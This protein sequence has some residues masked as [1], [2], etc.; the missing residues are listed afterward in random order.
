MPT[1]S[2][3]KIPLSLSSSEF[4]DIVRSSFKVRWDSPNLQR[5]GR[6]GQSQYGVDISGEDDLG[7]EVGIQCRAVEKITIA[8]I[9]KVT[10]QSE[11]FK[12]P[13]LAAFYMAVGLPRD[14][15]LFRQVRAIREERKKKGMYPVG[16]FFWEDILEELVASPT[17]FAKHYPDLAPQKYV[18]LPEH[19]AAGADLQTKVK[20]EAFAARQAV[21]S[22]WFELTEGLKSHPEMDWGDVVEW[23]AWDLA[24]C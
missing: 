3:M 16:I 19:G 8:D 1:I 7:R 18:V 20:Q 4:E 12:K 15:T 2:Q 9:K 13:K 21:Y 6:N 5:H 22:L 24:G 11:K 23:V 10:L 14:A 17:E